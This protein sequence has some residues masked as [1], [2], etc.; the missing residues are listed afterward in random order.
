MEPL[1]VRF[2]EQVVNPSFVSLQKPQTSQVPTHTSDHPRHA[3]H[4]LQEDYPVDP[5]LFSHVCWV[6]ASDF[7][8]KPSDAM[9]GLVSNL[10]HEGFGLPMGFLDVLE[11][12]RIIDE[13]RSSR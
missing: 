4:C 12:L 9:D 1:V 2:F 7:V 10:V 6:V 8:E 11:G 5:L 3:R 13:V